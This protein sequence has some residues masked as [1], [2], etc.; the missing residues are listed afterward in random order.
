MSVMLTVNG[1]PS[2]VVLRQAQ[3]KQVLA[4]EHV[5]VNLDV[6]EIGRPSE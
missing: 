1:W 5:L 2:F 4:Q 6:P 3:A